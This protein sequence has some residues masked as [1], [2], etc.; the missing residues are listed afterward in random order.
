M[1][2]K[3]KLKTKLQGDVAEVKSL[4]L[5]PMETGTRKDPDTGALIPAHH[6]TVRDPRRHTA[7][8]CRPLSRR[9]TDRNG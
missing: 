8:H 3:I 4:M 2:S 9:N 1:A 5:H 7:A 6:I